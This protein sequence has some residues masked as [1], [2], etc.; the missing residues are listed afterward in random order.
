MNEIENIIKK[1]KSNGDLVGALLVEPI[2]SCGGQIELPKDFL[3]DV[4]KIIKKEGI[5]AVDGL[6]NLS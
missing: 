4:Y 3:K 2:I 1:M 6:I 5:V